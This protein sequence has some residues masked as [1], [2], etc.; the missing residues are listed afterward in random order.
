MHLP[1]RRGSGV[2]SSARGRLEGVTKGLET[3]SIKAAFQRPR[4]PRSPRKGVWADP[5]CV[6][7]TEHR[8]GA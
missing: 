7:T 2:A 5:H 8:Q 1:K 3:P 4:A 6:C